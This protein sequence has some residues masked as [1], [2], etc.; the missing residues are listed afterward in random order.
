[1]TAWQR[2]HILRR[3]EKGLGSISFKRILLAGLAGVLVTLFGGRALGFGGSVC[4]GL[5]LCIGILVMTQPIQGR[6]AFKHIVEIAIGVIT[7]GALSGNESI[8]AKIAQLLKIESRSGAVEGEDLYEIAEEETKKSL[9]QAGF[10]FVGHRPGARP[11][12]AVD[13]PIL[14]LEALGRPNG[15]HS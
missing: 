3:E 14:Q 13:A 5:A 9:S 6:L 11:L 8:G 7:V 1:M 12:K 4:S 10:L 15:D 2:T